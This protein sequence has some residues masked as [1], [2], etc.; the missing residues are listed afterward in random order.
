MTQ[1][2]SIDLSQF[3]SF[4]DSANNTI[5]CNSDCKR[6]KHISS[7]KQKVMEAKS[8]VALAEPDYQ[9][10][11]KNYL[12]YTKGETEYNDLMEQQ[13]TSVANDL[14]ATMHE[15]MAKTTTEITQQIE[16]Y[17]GLLVN[18]QNVVDLYEQYKQENIALAK[19]LKEDATDI[20]TNE[21]KTYYEDQETEWTTYVYYIL[22]IIYIISAIGYVVFYLKTNIHMLTIWKTIKL[23]IVIGIPWLMKWFLRLLV[24][25]VYWVAGLFPKNT[26]LT[27]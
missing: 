21:R 16:S 4:L 6:K 10:A 25:F 11:V 13:Y 14:A 8:N 24:M 26:Y 22:L 19:Q 15:Q 23:F 3:N 17:T 18:M 7:L 12:V 5:S 20:I 1:Q 27:L 9:L 2:S